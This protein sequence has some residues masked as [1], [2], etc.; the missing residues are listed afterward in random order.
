MSALMYNYC[1][2]NNGYFSLLYIEGTMTVTVCQSGQ[3]GAREQMISF[4]DDQ[5]GILKDR[6]I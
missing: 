5:M 4:L 6:K 3:I 2:G 1:H